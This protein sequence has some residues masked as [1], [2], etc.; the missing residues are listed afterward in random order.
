M[1]DLAEYGVKLADAQTG[2][3]EKL[4]EQGKNGEIAKSL[5]KRIAV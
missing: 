1:T 3:E 5:S 4:E 2:T